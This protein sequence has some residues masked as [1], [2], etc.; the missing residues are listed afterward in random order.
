MPRPLVR[1]DVYKNTETT[2][3]ILNPPSAP[4]VPGLSSS[5]A[6]LMGTSLGERSW[7]CYP[8]MYAGF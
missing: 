4:P 1:R 3:A 8:E 6:R 5:A 7:M 2:L